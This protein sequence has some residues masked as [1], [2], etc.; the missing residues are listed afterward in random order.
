MKS[1][2]SVA[3]VLIAIVA[4]AVFA[5][6]TYLDA[7]TPELW[8][9]TTETML[10]QE[11]TPVIIGQGEALVGELVRLEA[12]GELVDWSCLPL[13]EDLQEYGENDQKCV[14]SFRNPG[15]YNVIAAVYKDGV[16]SVLHLSIIVV[17]PVVPVPDIPIP[18]ITVDIDQKLIDT[19]AKWCVDSRANKSN[20]E[21]L[22]TVFQMVA[23][24]IQSGEL[25]TTTGIIARTAE[26][27]QEIDLTGLGNVLSKIQKY[28]I[29]K[30][31]IGE[32][33]DIASHLTV[34]MSIAEGLNKYAV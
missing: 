26:L 31:D 33:E 34:W 12:L 27:N 16:V 8:K 29:E 2:V 6:E 23:L 30:S 18:D 11:G 21:D 9:Q 15:T 28:I 25:T 1:A 32:L 19:V 3:L 5:G 22:A 17:G 7:K 24:E 10:F 14:V 20:V 13:T 4:A